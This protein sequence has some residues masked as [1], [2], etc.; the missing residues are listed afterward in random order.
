[1][2]LFG[3]TYQFADAWVLW[4]LL[5]IPILVVFYIFIG[6]REVTYKTSI[7]PQ[8][9]TV[10]SGFA[11]F[12]KPFLFGLR[13]LALTFIITA[14]ARPQMSA[15]SPS[16][17][18]QYKE[19]IDI[20]IALDASGSMLAKDFEPDRFEASK[21][22][23]EEF[24]SK[25]PNDRIGLVLFEGEAYTQCPLTGDQDIVTELL[26]DAEMQ[27]V[28]PGT[29]IGMGLGTAVNRLRDSE[30]V[31]KVIILLTDGVNTH[32][33][34]HP[35]AAAEMAKEFGVRVYTIGV[36]TNGKAKTPVAID[37][38]GKYIY[39]Y[40]DVEIDEETLKTIANSTGGKYFR[41]TDNNKLAAIYDEIDQLEKAKIETIEYE[42]DLPEKSMP[43]ILLALGLISL[44]LI[45]RLIFRSLS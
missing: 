24:I 40:V 36:G 26:R 12:I 7:I 25:R 31:S 39:D 13:M 5:I 2:K 22:V 11:R 10:N 20:V 30:A 21:A 18:E 1:M 33:K 3:E 16:Y 15:E 45:T 9:A 44:E 29:A 6:N 38:S 19:G 23:A 32:G 35:L 42:I 41:A 8:G 34:I 43:L 37:F 28:E 4:F 14:L 27:V 17:V